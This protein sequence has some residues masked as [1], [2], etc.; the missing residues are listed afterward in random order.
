MKILHCPQNIGGMAGVIATKQ[1]EL[2]HQAYSYSFAN[3]VYNFQSDF[4]LENYYSP[5]ERLQKTISFIKDFDIFQ[6]YFGESLL[7]SSL[8]DVPWLSRLGKKIFFYFCGCDI[9]DEKATIMK[10]PISACANCFP[11]LCSK[12]RQV[13][14]EISRDYGIVNFVSTPDLLE[15]V[16][17]SILL[18]QVV[19]FE[20][21]DQ[22]L[23]ETKSIEKTKNNSLIIAHA[24]SNRK[25][26]GTDFILKCIDN[27][28]NKGLNIELKLI[29]NVPHKEALKIYKSADIAID[30]LLVGAYGL[31][32]AEMMALGVPTIVYLRENLLDKY[33]E[34]PPLINANPDNLEEVLMDIYDNRDKLEYYSNSGINYARSFHHPSKIAIQC[35]EYYE[36]VD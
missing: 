36:N 7:G 17:R 31:L 22:I 3:N 11:K 26:K 23:V 4:S 14:Y 35:L 12:N 10:Y 21:I 27:L 28:K 30:Q 34:E 13:A 24:P 32:S 19:D 8:A 6:F 29:E 33:P 5:I 20:I 9:R 15:F 18:P 16:E 1:S 2:G 25:I